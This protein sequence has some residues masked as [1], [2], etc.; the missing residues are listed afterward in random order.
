[1]IDLHEMVLIW[2]SAVFY[3]LHKRHLKNRFRRTR[4]TICCFARILFLRVVPRTI[5]SSIITKL[6]VGLITPYVMSYTCS[7]RSSLLLSSVMKVRS[8]TS[9]IAIFSILGCRDKISV[10]FSAERDRLPAKIE[11]VFFLFNSSCLIR[12]FL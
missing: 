9:L 5:L 2:N 1:M 4:H 7:T 8:L 10:T 3:R 6:S 11:A 12:I